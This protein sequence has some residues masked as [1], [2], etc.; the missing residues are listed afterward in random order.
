VHERE[1]D[2]KRSSPFK[3]PTPVALLKNLREHKIKGKGT[4]AEE[5]HRKKNGN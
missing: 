2:T 4:A 5:T 3:E 1:G